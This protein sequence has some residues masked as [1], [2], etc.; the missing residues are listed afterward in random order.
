MWSIKTFKTFEALEK[1]IECNDH[2]YQ[3]N[4]VFICN[5]YALEIKKKCIIDIK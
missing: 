2:K 5:G 4:Q 3:Y 1:W